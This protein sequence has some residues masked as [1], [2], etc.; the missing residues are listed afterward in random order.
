MPKPMVCLSATLRQFCEAFRSCFSKRQW[1]YFVIVLLGL[2]ECEQRRT[3]S[4]LLA[5]IGEQVRLSGLSRF[6]HCWKWL[7]EELARIWLSRFRQQWRAEVEAEHQ[8]QAA[9]R[10]KR[11]GRPKKTVV[12]GY[13][14]FDDS[15]HIKPR[16]KKM[17][18]LGQHYSRTEPRVAT[19]HN[20]LAGW[21]VLLGR[22]CPLPPRLYRQQSVCQ[23]EHAPLQSKIDLVIQKIERFEPVEGTPTHVLLD[24]WFHC[25]A[26]R[27][28]AQGH[29]WEVSGGW[30]SNRKMRRIHPDGTRRWMT[31]AE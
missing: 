11:R 21:S 30:K 24:S 28:A 18:G 3:L 13:L 27:K 1:Q 29:G 9:E 2:I 12:T 25:K 31:L 17:Q 15:V 16:G 14:I 19:G 4:G 7:T 5:N 10:E 23:K 8:R 26:V 22:R 6:C 20:L